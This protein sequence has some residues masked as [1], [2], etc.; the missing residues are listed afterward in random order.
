MSITQAFRDGVRR[1][2]QAPAVLAGVFLLALLLALPLG[3]TLRGMLRESLGDSLAAETMASGVNY[4]WWQEFAEQAQGIGGTF[5]P[6]IIGFGAVLDNASS[7]LDNRTHATVVA[8]AGTAYVL[9]WIFLVGGILDRYA[10]N[11]ATRSAAF[12]AACGTFF[13]RFLRLAVMAW[14]GYY[15]LFRYLH[16]WLFDDF[17]GWATRDVTVERTAF[18]LR[19][20]LYLVFGVLL[21]AWNL[22]I[23]YAKVRAVVEDRR[24]MIGA[25]LGGIRFV[26]R[27]PRS[28]TGLYLLDGA[29]FVLV[30]AVYAV[31]APGAGSTGWSMWLGFLLGQLF[32]LGRLWV[33]LVF[34]ASETSLFQAALAHAEYT[35]AP[36]PVWPE[37]PAAEAIA[38]PPAQ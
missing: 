13:F 29:L 10:R 9:S 26:V 12:F 14:I 6:R 28:A 11:R 8:A 32:V 20:T 19:A 37:S 24:S 33:K 34:W 22:F 25:L 38:P 31:V 17:F 5:S 36:L 4:D 2:N 35:A 21:L 3:L 7:M 27:H 15:L 1:V 16:R 30:V 18:L 23:D